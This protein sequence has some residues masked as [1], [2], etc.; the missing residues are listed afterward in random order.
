MYINLEA[1][2]NKRDVISTK[3]LIQNQKLILDKLETLASDRDK[4]ATK[5]DI[6]KLESK[7]DRLED[8]LE[9]LASDRDKVATKEDIDKLESKTDRLEDKL[10][11]LASDRDKV[12]TKEDI[13]KLES[14]TDRLEDKLESKIDQ[15]SSQVKELNDRAF[16]E[17]GSLGNR[18]TRLEHDSKFF[19]WIGGI[20]GSGLI[21]FIVLTFKKFFS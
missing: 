6:D 1:F 8:K 10:E 14:K 20:V 2:L 12:A 19:K 15:V 4:V 18:V 21:A 17:Q 3:E 13:G 9:T 16:S 7:T 5:E 11:T